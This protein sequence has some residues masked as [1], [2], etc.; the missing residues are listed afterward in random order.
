[1]ESGVRMDVW[2]SLAEVPKGLRSVVTIGNFD[3]MHR[4]HTRV[5]GVAVRKANEIAVPAVALTFDP[6]PKAVHRP[7]EPFAL[8]TSIPHRLDALAATGVTG[9]LVAEYGPSIYEMTAREFA[10]DYL[11]AGLGAAEVVVGE[12]FRFG[13][14]NEGN[15]TT[16][17]ELGVQLGFTVTVVADIE[18]GAGRRWSSSWVR[19]LL[20]EGAVGEAAEVLGRP[21]R[22]VGT[23]EHGSKR[24]RALGFPTANLNAGPGVLAPAD[25]VYAGWL[26]RDLPEQDGAQEFL[27]AA[28]SVG[29]NPHFKGTTRTVEAH[30]LGRTDLDLYG[31]EVGVIFTKR[32]RPMRAFEDV[33]ELTDQMEDDLRQTAAALGARVAGR[34]DPAEVTAGQ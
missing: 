22:L 3:G 30:V 20:A 34:V 10:E 7:E 31:D 15:V 17:Q 21:Y 23:V 26:V 13:R 16:L 33:Q 28:I 24:G 1:M 8:I 25:G 2:W 32:I 9:V 19:R 27:P 5:V 29:S 4:G 11:V 12:D 18:D 14:G 6:H